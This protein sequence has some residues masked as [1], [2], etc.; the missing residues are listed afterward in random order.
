MNEMMSAG[1]ELM[2]VGMGIVFLFLGMLVIAINAMSALIQ[3]HFPEAPQE[4]LSSPPATADD[5]VI[6]AIA[7]AVHQYRSKHK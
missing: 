5:S 6:A 7:A 4:L 3:R 2:L 1:I